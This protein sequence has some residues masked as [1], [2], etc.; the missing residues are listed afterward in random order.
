M[1]DDPYAMTP[2]QQALRN[3]LK[4][5]VKHARSVVARAVRRN[6]SGHSGLPAR[7]TLRQRKED[8]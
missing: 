1:A 2:Y 6:S 3:L 4:V 7:R 5:T 8:S